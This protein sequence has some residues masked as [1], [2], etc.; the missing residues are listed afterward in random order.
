[1]ADLYLVA[2]REVRRAQAQ[3]VLRTVRDAGDALPV[4]THRHPRRL[5]DG[6]GL[7]E[8]E[9]AACL[10]RREDDDI[11]R[12]LPADLVH[13]CRRE[14]RLVGGDG[15]GDALPD[16]THRR[17]A[18]QR[19]RLLD[20]LGLEPAQSADHVDGLGHAPDAVGIEPQAAVADRL[21][22][23][24]RVAHVGG[25]AA[26]DLQIDDTIARGREV[27]GIFCELLRGVAL[28]EA[29]VV[30]LLADRA[31]KKPVH[32]LARGLA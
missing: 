2:I 4:Q 22:N 1:M 11:G 19:R 24:R 29:E 28:D 12:T 9:Q 6:D 20:P 7:A 18:H 21:A 5:G 32:R 10:V 31:A 27:A 15:H 8:G 23:G 30:D 13:V 25:F 26:S 3:I 17:D 14:Y 16:L